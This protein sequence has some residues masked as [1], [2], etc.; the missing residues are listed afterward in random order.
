[1]IVSSGDLPRPGLSAAPNAPSA[2]SPR[3]R[4][5]GAEPCAPGAGSAAYPR[6]AGAPWCWPGCPG[7]SPSAPPARSRPRPPSHRS[8]GFAAHDPPR[9]ARPAPAQPD[10]QSPS[11]PAAPPT[12]CCPP[13]WPAAAA[14]HPALILTCRLPALKRP[15]TLPACRAMRLPCITPDGV[16]HIQLTGDLS[17]AL[18]GSRYW[19]GQ[20]PPGRK[21][22][23]GGPPPHCFADLRD[24]D[25]RQGDAGADEPLLDVEAR[26]LEEGL[27]RPEDGGQEEHQDRYA[28]GDVEG[29]VGER[30]ETEHRAP[31]VFGGDREEQGIQRERDDAHVCAIASVCTCSAQLM[32][33]SVPA[34]ITS[35]AVTSQANRP[36]VKMGWSG[37][38]GL[39]SI[40]PSAGLP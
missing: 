30:I 25:D 28:G 16:S 2:R 11:P 22:L 3:P 38:R 8:G 20:E 6:P 23:S 17:A 19:R 14:R 18:G 4:G 1:M 9:P 35:P 26:R 39:R 5:P 12:C 13:R 24:H 37:W 34:P 31:F 15:R 21:D 27:Q 7:R 10:R 36:R 40:S 33:P 32:T 29:L